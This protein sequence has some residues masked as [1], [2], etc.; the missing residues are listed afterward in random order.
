MLIGFSCGFFVAAES[1]G[2]TKHRAKNKSE[3]LAFGLNCYIAAEQ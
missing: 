3:N 1:S 2:K